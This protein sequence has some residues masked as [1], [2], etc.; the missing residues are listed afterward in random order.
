MAVTYS[1]PVSLGTSA[2][3][4]SLPGVDEKTYTLESFADEKFLVV[5]FICNHCPYII[6]VED[7]IVEIANAYKNKGVGFVAIS[8]NNA[9]VY[10]E[11]SFEKMKIRSDEKNFSFPYLYDES[12]EV[13]KTYQAA[14]T[15]D[16]FVYDKE[17]KLVYHGRIND[18][19]RGESPVTTNDLEEA[20]RD[21]LAGNEV[22]DQ[23]P[24]VG[25]NIKWKE[26]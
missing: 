2:H 4:F 23:V 10:T 9:E 8:S 21:L 26:E 3:N 24:S 15:P 13:A 20:L 22:T 5:L 1:I 19:E 14:C 7:Q 25:C 16:V 18:I 17:R 6:A 12:Q 11:D